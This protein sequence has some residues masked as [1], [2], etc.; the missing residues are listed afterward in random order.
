MPQ[1]LKIICYGHTLTHFFMELFEVV[2]KFVQISFD[3]VNWC[4]VVPLLRDPSIG[5]PLLL[6]Y[7]SFRERCIC[8]MNLS[9]LKDHLSCKTD[10]C[11][12]KTV[13]TTLPTNASLQLLRQV[14]VVRQW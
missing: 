5:R 13:E 8:C 12:C 14:V 9:L 3:M 6:R 10:F 11:H 1:I 2:G 7:H 4:K